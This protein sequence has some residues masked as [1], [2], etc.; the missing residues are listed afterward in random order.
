MVTWYNTQT[1]A[2]SNRSNIIYQ[3]AEIAQYKT[4]SC[5]NGMK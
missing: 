5:Y 1:L 4:L 3:V 2:Q